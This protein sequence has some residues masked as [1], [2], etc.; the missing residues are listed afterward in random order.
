VSDFGPGSH[1]PGDGPD[2][3]G[4][5]FSR[6]GGHEQVGSL[7]EEAAK[8]L[9]AL[10]GWAR[11]HVSDYSRTASEFGSSYIADGSAAC[12]L[13]PVCQLIAFVRG[14]N[15][16]SLEQ[17]GHAAGSMLQALSGLVEA[18]HRSDS[19]RGSPVQKIHLADDDPEDTP[20]H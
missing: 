6:P 9:A 1:G 14:I 15:P 12:R 11:E 10:Q 3:H 20:W 4:H 18:A 5:G 2:G 7:G 19:R 8:L 17:L 16:D 13:C